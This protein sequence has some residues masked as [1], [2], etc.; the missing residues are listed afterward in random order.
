MSHAL[1]P[2]N[3][4]SI[5]GWVKNLKRGSLMSSDS[6]N[7]VQ[8]P[9]SDPDDPSQQQEFLRPLLQHKSRSTNNVNRARSNSNNQSERSSNLRQHRDS[10]LQH[11][12]LVDENS[13]Y[14]GISLDRAIDLASAKISIFG[15]TSSDQMLQYGR[16]PVVV[17]KC[18][19]YLKTNG[20][21][22]EGIFRV[23]GSSRRL[24]ELQLVFNTPPEFGKKL[25]WD[26]F[27]VHDAASILRRY[28]NALPEPLIPLD[29]YEKFRDPLR[30]RPRIVN[31]MK[32]KAENPYKSI[33]DIST[34]VATSGVA[35]SELLDKS[36][37]LTET[38]MGRFNQ[39][40]E[41]IYTS[42]PRSQD[43]PATND[44]T[45]DCTNASSSA[46]D[47]DTDSK[48]RRHRNY[49]KLTRDVHDAIKDYKEMVDI[50]PDLSKQL[51]FYILDLLAMV[52]N[53]SDVNLMSS[54][55]LAAIFQPSILSHPSHDMD[56]IEYALSQLVVEFL[57]QYA[58]KLLPSHNPDGLRRSS[59]ALLTMDAGEVGSPLK[60]AFKRHHSKSLSSTNNQD[61][62][63]G[64]QNNVNSKALPIVDSDHE[65]DISD[66]E[67]ET[68]TPGT[69]SAAVAIPVPSAPV[70]IL[71]SP[72]GVTPH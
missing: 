39:Q 32:Y 11:N 20:L 34:S 6:V 61:D 26:G 56:P 51:L 57:I 71:V 22:V 37:P 1:S 46:P 12:P 30:N 7:D 4:N 14:F 19:V 17:A 38:N 49:K 48:E 18:G 63:V 41:P 45:K 33:K 13:Q 64:Y 69:V 8:D 60:P 5:F 52:Q 62:F 43:F 40:R 42:D 66:D 3:R 27:T 9:L 23:G 36:E 21:K 28:L 58:Y 70:A 35:S 2:T 54:R 44:Q 67:E 15:T 47:C 10:F 31:Y 25:S 29:L 68:H 72:P 24:K 16:I 50:L 65:Y 59:K 55:N 53:H